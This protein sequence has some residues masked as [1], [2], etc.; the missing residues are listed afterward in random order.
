[1]TVLTQY[2]GPTQQ[3]SRLYRQSD[4]FLSLWMRLRIVCLDDGLSWEFGERLTVM[5]FKVFFLICLQEPGLAPHG[6][7]LGSAG[8]AAT[9]WEK[10]KLHAHVS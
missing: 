9:S 10:R 5:I 6:W 1:M 2:A 8:P 3:N 4:L 7:S